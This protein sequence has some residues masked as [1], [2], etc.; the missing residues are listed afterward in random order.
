MS[1]ALGKGLK[2]RKRVCDG[3]WASQAIGEICARILACRLSGSVPQFV[4]S[5]TPSVSPY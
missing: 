4:Q 3:V 2:A 5:L 1:L